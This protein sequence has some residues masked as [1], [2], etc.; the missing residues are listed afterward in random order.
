MSDQY[1]RTPCPSKIPGVLIALCMSLPAQAQDDLDWLMDESPSQTRDSDPEQTS[2]AQTSEP[3][4]VES[5][6]DNKPLALIPLAEKPPDKVRPKAERGQLE[7]I[8]VTAQRRAQD[9][10]DVPIAISVMDGEAMRDAA[11]SNF[12][13]MARFIPNVSFNTDFNSLYLRGIGTAELNV[14]G[15]QAVSYILDDVYV[16]RLDFLK[17]GFLDVN[18]IEVLKG[19]QGTLFGRNA[20]GGVIKIDYGDPTPEWEGYASIEAGDL[21]RLNGEAAISGPISERF[22]FRLAGRLHQETGSVFN[23]F[24]SNSNHDKDIALARLKI[25]GQLTDTLEA[26][27]G[28][29]HLDYFLGN[30]IGDEFHIYPDSLRDVAESTEGFESALDRRN[31]I[32]RENESIGKGFIAPLTLNWQVLDHDLSSVTAFVGLKDSI[33]GDVEGLSLRASELLVGQDFKQFSQEFRLVSPPGRFNYVAGLYYLQTDLTAGIDVPIYGEGLEFFA[34]T[35]PGGTL[36]GIPGFSDLL[37]P[38]AAPADDEVVSNLV[39]DFT[40][41]VKAIGIY[42]QIDWEVIDNVNLILGLRY[43]ND[44]KHGT[45]VATDSGPTPIWLSLI[46]GGYT[47]DE[48][49]KE[50]KVSGKVSATWQI[51]DSVT[52][53]GTFAQGYRAG[54]FNV[55]AFTRDDLIFAPEESDT[56][57]AGIKTELFG[58]AVRANLGGY[59]TR[60]RDYQLAQLNGLTYIQNNAPGTESSGIEADAM[61]LLAPGLIVNASFG[62]NRAIF[63]DFSEGGCPAEDADDPN[64][65]PSGPIALPPRPTCDLTG[66]PLHRAPKYTGSLAL[67]YEWPLGPVN[68]IMGADATYKGSEFMDPDLDPDDSEEGYWL[69]NARLGVAS[70]DNQ[71]R[72]ELHGK[73]L[74]DELVKTFSGDVP[75]QSGA[76]WALTNS[77]RTFFATL[78]YTFGNL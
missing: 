71:W 4:A 53:Y 27:L 30:F 5:D 73:N 68:M 21:D 3:K 44:D 76:H 10:R 17:P 56:Y 36:A 22:S 50:S 18:R 75:F 31:A 23:R 19:P 58:G 66:K 63:T 12:D 48:T 45:A 64:F 2:S 1:A 33:L 55:A 14:I 43:S 40:V 20:T 57:E 7:E 61:A 11:I 69:Y 16:P 13:D 9:V 28:Y 35:T 67:S 38:G 42:G 39:G 29:T 77:P 54:S 78:R 60:Y 15:E 6:V 74:S 25:A 32:S 46:A 72:L 59:L 24:T 49:L 47:A 65:R 62:Y 52:A 70:Q 26:E 34:A 8:V 51:S 41:D 37:Q